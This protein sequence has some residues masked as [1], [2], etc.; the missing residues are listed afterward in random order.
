MQRSLAMEEGDQYLVYLVRC[1]CNVC[2][3]RPVLARSRSAASQRRFSSACMF[4]NSDILFLVYSLSF[5]S[6]TK[7]TTTR[8][9]RLNIKIVIIATQQEPKTNK[10]QYAQNDAALLGS[11]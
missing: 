4:L 8:L 2:E 5:P 6:R 7:Q 9:Y 11:K 1:H 3:V 10:R